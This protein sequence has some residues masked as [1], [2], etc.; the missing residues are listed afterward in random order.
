MDEFGNKLFLVL[1]GFHPCF[2]MTISW[3]KCCMVHFGELQCCTQ[4]ETNADMTVAVMGCHQGINPNAH[5]QK[6]AMMQMVS[7]DTE[8]MHHQ[9]K[10]Y[11]LFL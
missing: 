9:W 7:V 6:V 11:I 10:T 5:H 4:S 2:S 1:S 8:K 3:L